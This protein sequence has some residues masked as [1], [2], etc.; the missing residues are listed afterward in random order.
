VR[1][2]IVAVIKDLAIKRHPEEMVGYVKDGEF[3]ELKNISKNPTQRYQL[4]IQDKMHV[5]G[6]QVD[7]LVH[8]HPNMSN[9]P[10]DLDSAAQRATG[11]EFWIVGTDGKNTTD[12]KE[13][14]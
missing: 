5:L 3:I 2:D 13:I 6:S 1:K 7:A 9:D 12:I 10:S 11:L 14:K 8:S 4:S